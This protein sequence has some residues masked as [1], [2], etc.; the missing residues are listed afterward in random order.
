MAPLL[1]L[2]AV[3]VRINESTIL[4]N[5]DFI[6]QQG[7]HW[8]IIGPSGAGKTAL[9][10][11]ITGKLPINSGQIKRY[12]ADE[13]L[14]AAPH[15]GTAHTFHDLLAITSPQ[16]T[17]KNKSNVQSF[18]YQQRFNST[19][20]EEAD[21]VIDYLKAVKT[22]IQAYWTVDKVVSLLDLSSLLNKTIIKLSNGE[23]R[24]LTIALALLRNPKLLLMD[25]PLIGLD[26]GTRARFNQILQQII[27]SGIHLIITTPANE[28]PAVATH[29]AYLANGE[30]KIAGK[31]TSVI[32]STSFPLQAQLPTFQNIE[33][34]QQELASY[35]L[36]AFQKIIEMKGVNVRYGDKPILTDINWDVIQG[37]RWAIKGHNGAGKS[38]LLSLINGDNPQAYA[39]HIVLFDRR[40]GSGESIWEIK[41]KIGFVSPEQHQYFPTEQTCLQ[42]I[43]S[44][45]FDTD[46][47]FRK[48]SK[49]QDEIALRWMEIFG[50]KHII[51]KRLKT[52][53]TSEQRL[54]LLARALIKKPVLLILDEPCQGLSPEQRD[55]FKSVVNELC[56]HSV[57]TILYVSHY[58]ED[59]PSLINQT[60]LLEKGYRIN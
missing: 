46:G 4:K 56:L 47:L 57:V 60:L 6:V 55:L 45:F 16:H 24:R 41:K 33:M 10:H 18:Y 40:R 34:L 25:Q 53:P 8:A 23:T 59:I 43:L 12:F 7:Q 13:Y 20:A 30:I 42:T 37:E 51:A 52:V 29:V 1:N 39:N 22:P 44:G 11:T 27:D 15:N 14:Q 19:D 35:A 5:I 50:I 54:C 28:I 49:E 3:T 21:T 2:I 38:T 58:A 36:P 9:L 17:F 31:K 48:T 26:I 32:A